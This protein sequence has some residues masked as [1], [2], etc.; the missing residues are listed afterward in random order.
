MSTAV[1]WKTAERAELVGETI[2]GLMQ[3]RIPHS[4]RITGC[5][6][7]CAVIAGV[8]DPLDF[9]ARFDRNRRGRK[10]IAAGAD[11]HREGFRERALSQKN[12]KRAS[13]DGETCG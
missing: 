7:G 2:A 4:R 11:V 10:D 5:A 6:R 12:S 9:V 3:A 13:E 8:P 1:V